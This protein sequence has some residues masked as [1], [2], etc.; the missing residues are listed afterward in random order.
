MSDETV[1]ELA[2]TR[3]RVPQRIAE[4]AAARRRPVAALGEGRTFI[5]AADHSARG[6]VGTG[7]HPDA[8]ADRGD[9]LE[10][11]SL[12]LS[13]PGV[14]GVLGSPDI[15]EDL[16][17]LGVLDGMA[18]FGSMNRGGIKGALWEIDDRFTA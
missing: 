8:M 15:L 10:R 18:V 1:R 14:T 4:A 2:L 5:V 12:A 7:R 6:M 9:L 13:R 16:L 17:L 3:A 11:L